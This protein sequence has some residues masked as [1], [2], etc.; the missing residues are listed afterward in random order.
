MLP[1][2]A[3]TKSPQQIMGLFVKKRLSAALGVRCVQKRSR[4]CHATEGNLCARS[5]ADL[6]H[7]TVMPCFDKKLEGSRDDFFDAEL[8]TREVNRWPED[9]RGPPPSHALCVRWTA[10]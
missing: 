10:C 3:A 6:I 8:Q 7:V 5:P 1:L 4:T 9:A 2:L